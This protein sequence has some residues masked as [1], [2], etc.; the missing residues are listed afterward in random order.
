[1]STPSPVLGALNAWRLP[2]KHVA[3]KSPLM[4]LVTGEFV[5]EVATQLP[6]AQPSPF[7]VVIINTAQFMGPKRPWNWETGLS[8][9]L[10]SA[11]QGLFV[12]CSDRDIGID[13][14]AWMLRDKFAVPRERLQFLVS[15][16]EGPGWGLFVD[17][18]GAREQVQAALNGDC[19][20]M[21][22][23]CFGLP[24]SV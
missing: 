1:M 18:H 3:L 20:K 9:A 5:R 4:S 14:V 2:I 13:I 8:V 12:T 7:E 6:G 16:H 15:E 21:A 17:M 23:V 10:A 11:A 24:L 22:W 19:S